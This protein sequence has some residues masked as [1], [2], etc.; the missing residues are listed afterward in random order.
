LLFNLREDPGEQN[1][2]ADEHPERVMAMQQD[3]ADFEA[4][5]TDLQPRKEV[6]PPADN[7]HHKYLREKYGSR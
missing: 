3:I 2:L 5:L 6:K 4:G 1:N 7:S